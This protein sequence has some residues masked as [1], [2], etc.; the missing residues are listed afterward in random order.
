MVGPRVPKE[1][2][3][4][5]RNAFDRLLKDEEFLASLKKQNLE[6]SPM[7][8]E[9]LQQL[10]MRTANAPKPIIDKTRDALTVKR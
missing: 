5:L 2:V 9:E 8:G 4:I 7:S 3:A 10:V 1:R 6:I